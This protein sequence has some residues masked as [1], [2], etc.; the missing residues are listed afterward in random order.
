MCLHHRLNF[1]EEDQR[2]QLS[3]KVEEEDSFH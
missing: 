2:P 3:P 1:Q